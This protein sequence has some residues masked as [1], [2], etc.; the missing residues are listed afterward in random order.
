[1]R[2][3]MATTAILVSTLTLVSGCGEDTPAT[4]TGDIET[5]EITFEDGTVTPN[6][7]RVEV[8]AGQPVDLV[9]KADEPG[10][11]HVHSEPEQQFEYAAGTTTLKL[12]IDQ[13]GVV[14]VE[15]HDLE[16]VI[17]QLEVS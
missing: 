17:V 1:M 11:I 8:G 3:L 12:T 5:I 14:E 9:V 6:G 10:E 7:E 4:D 16:Q 13:P 2:R 15:S